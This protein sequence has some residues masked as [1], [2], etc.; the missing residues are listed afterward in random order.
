MGGYGRLVSGHIGGWHQK[1]SGAARQANPYVSF[2]CT[3][4]AKPVHETCDCSEAAYSPVKGCKPETEKLFSTLTYMSAAVGEASVAVTVA[5]ARTRTWLC[6]PIFFIS[7]VV[8]RVE[9]HVN[10]N[11]WGSD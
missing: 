5:K 7:S 11:L 10:L 4:A 6:L 8:P 9:L 3:T 2:T 1:S